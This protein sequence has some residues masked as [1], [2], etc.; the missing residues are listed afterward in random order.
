M[1]LPDAILAYR[2]L[3]SANLSSE[4]VD[5]AL[6]TV[7]EFTYVEMISTISKIFSVH[8]NRSGLDQVTGSCIKTEPEESCNFTSHG[9]RR[10]R[11]QDGGPMRS[12]GTLRNQG[13]PY[14]RGKRPRSQINCFNC[15]KNGHYSRECTNQA[16]PNPN[17]RSEQGTS[18]NFL[19]QGQPAEMEVD[20]SLSRTYITL[21][22]TVADPESVLYQKNSEVNSLVFETL[23]CAVIDS[24]CT[25]SVVGE[26]WVSQYIETLD[27]AE[28]E[29]IMSSTSCQTPFTFG[30]G[31]SV[32]SNKLI[33]IP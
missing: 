27:D 32:V 30:D 1:E 4:K 23:S 20:D 15:G 26:N 19:V 11:G 22:T 8:V 29:I 28:R 7:K 2:V 18:R 31:K 3:N 33:K 10:S 9:Y 25:K 17:W 12:R 5:L 6:A 14:V 21:L 24:G 16:A 13:N